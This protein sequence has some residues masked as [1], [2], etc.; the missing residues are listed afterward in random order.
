MFLH[1]PVGFLNRPL[2]RSDILLAD[3]SPNVSSEAFVTFETEAAFD[4][5]LFDA[6]YILESL[7]FVPLRKCGDKSER[8]NTK[9]V[10]N[11]P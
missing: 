7:I 6:V 8:Y 3:S 5:R 4:E 9:N 1:V 2:V 11:G 10:T